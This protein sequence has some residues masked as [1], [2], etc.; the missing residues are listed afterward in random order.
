MKY[1]F[2]L[3]ALCLLCNG[4]IEAQGYATSSP[5]TPS[6]SPTIMLPSTI[7]SS[8]LGTSNYITPNAKARVFTCDALLNR[9]WTY[10][11]AQMVLVCGEAETACVRY[12]MLQQTVLKQQ[13]EG[14]TQG[15]GFV[16]DALQSATEVCRKEVQ[17]KLMGCA[18]SLQAL[19]S[20]NT[21]LLNQ[22]GFEPP[23]AT[24]QS[25]MSPTPTPKK[26]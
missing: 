9:N 21:S 26:K 23:S 19:G 3:S 4:K 7:D 13:Q 14:I 15:D 10:S 25:S 1:Y 6:Q 2:F 24:P 18:V 5:S 11:N 17:F 20:S 8:L 16:M 12:G 22:S